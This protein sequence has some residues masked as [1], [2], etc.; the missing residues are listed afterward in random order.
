MSSN[1]H[2]RS[3]RKPRRSSRNTLI[4]SGVA[5]GVFTTLAVTGAASPT[6][7]ASQASAADSTVEMPTLSGVLS[8]G[9]AEAA[10]ATQTIAIQYDVEAAKEQAAAGARKAAAETREKAEAKAEAKRKAAAKK[11]AEEAAEAEEAERAAAERAEERRT[12]SRSS[13]R[14]DAPSTTSAPAPAPSNATGSA[15]AVV[16]FARAQVGKAYVM[17]A[18]GPSAYDCSGLTGAAFRQVGIDLPRISQDQSVTGT[19]VPLS[20]VQPGDILY[21][22]SAGSAYHVAI[23]VG[24]GKFV[25]AQNSSTGVVE[26]DMSWDMP[27]GAVRVL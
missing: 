9:A 20:Q 24:D 5:G 2:I 3:H 23:Y 18:T 14:P 17:G 8:A 10:H 6:S 22:G 11:A 27:T 26:R 16:N 15:A 13:E 25:G 1:A 21:W 12:A 7:A 4:R 19:Q